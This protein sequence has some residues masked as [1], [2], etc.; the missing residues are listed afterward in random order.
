M[1]QM[2]PLL[3]ARRDRQPGEPCVANHRL[4]LPPELLQNI[5]VSPRCRKNGIL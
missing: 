2:S 1:P 4:E 5:V 3:R